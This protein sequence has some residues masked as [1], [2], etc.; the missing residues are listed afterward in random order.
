VTNL[1]ATLLWGDEA[2]EEELLGLRFRDPA[3]RVPADEHRDG[4]AALRAR[5]R[6]AG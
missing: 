6:A 1:P 4:R 3:E 5:D 2:I